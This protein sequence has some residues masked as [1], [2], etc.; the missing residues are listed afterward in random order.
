MPHSQGLSNN[1]YPWAE[2]TQFPALIPISSKFILILS[3]HLRLDLL[4][5][6]FPECL[7]VKILKFYA[8]P[9]GD[10]KVYLWIL[11]C[12]NFVLFTIRFLEVAKFTSLIPLSLLSW[13]TF[14]VPIVA[15]KI[16]S[17]PTFALKSP[18]NCELIEKSLYFFIKAIFNIIVLI[19]W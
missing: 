9:S 10:V 18:N 19:L 5:G 4:K 16:F 3:S 14:S 8:I 11:R 7:P 6:L 12:E 13:R 15:W 1:H 2:S 17:R